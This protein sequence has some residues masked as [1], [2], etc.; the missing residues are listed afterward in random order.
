[1]DMYWVLFS[2]I[3]ASMVCVIVVASMIKCYYCKKLKMEVEKINKDKEIT[4]LL[5]NIEARY[6]Q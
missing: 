5:K 2:L 1:M 6:N 4:D 3:A